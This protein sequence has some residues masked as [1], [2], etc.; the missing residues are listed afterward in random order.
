MH[1]THKTVDFYLLKKGLLRM[2]LQ[3]SFD[4]VDLKRALE[5]A[6]QVAPYADIIE[7]GMML[8]YHHGI[9][10]IEQ[11]RQTLPDKTL[12]ADAKIVDRGKQAVTAIG[13]TGADWISVMAGTNK[14]VI[15]SACSTA[16]ELKKK[17]VL[18]L[19]DANP[20]A[21]AALD[22]KNLGASSLLLHQPFEAQDPMQFIEQWQMVRGNTDLPIFVSAHITRKNIEQVLQVKPGGIVVGRGIVEADNPA[23]EAAY[24]K[25]IIES[26]G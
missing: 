4:I 1:H 9:A 18:D 12:L 21:Q 19:L 8:I 16:H 5:I 15:H 20:P 14:N 22:A 13:N 2:K 23:Q 7:I 6:Q 26:A 25:K 11:F 17:I 10:A 24:F 3:I